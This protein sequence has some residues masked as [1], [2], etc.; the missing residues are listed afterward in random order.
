MCFVHNQYKNN[1]NDN[2]GP[3]FIK[4]QKGSNNIPPNSLDWIRGGIRL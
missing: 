2:N 3:S 4:C 1:R